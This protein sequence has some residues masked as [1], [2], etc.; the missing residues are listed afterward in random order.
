M[1]GPGSTFRCNDINER[2]SAIETKKGSATFSS[3]AFRT[4]FELPK[5][6]FSLL[7]L[8]YQN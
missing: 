2:D 5:D 6:F 1:A 7:M 4:N 3:P 8:S